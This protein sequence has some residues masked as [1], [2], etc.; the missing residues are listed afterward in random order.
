MPGTLTC[1]VNEN[2]LV[3]HAL[4]GSEEKILA[5]TAELETRV[6]EIFR[7]KLEEVVL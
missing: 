7:E 2:Q 6:A 3:V 4:S 5:E 1:E